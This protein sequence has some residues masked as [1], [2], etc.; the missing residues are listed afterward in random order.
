[1]LGPIGSLDQNVEFGSVNQP[2][3]HVYELERIPMALWRRLPRLLIVFVSN[4]LS[5]GSGPAN[6]GGGLIRVIE[7]STGQVVGTFVEELGDDG[8]GTVSSMRADLTEMRADDF[9]RKWL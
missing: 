6:P 4:A 3:T 1:M 2:A 7:K 8:Q 9:A 5:M